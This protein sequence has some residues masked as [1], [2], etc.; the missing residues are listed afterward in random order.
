VKTRRIRFR[1][2][3]SEPLTKH[4]VANDIAMSHLLA[5]LSASFPPGEEAFIRAVR[6]YADQIADPALAQQVKGFIGQEMTHGREHRNLNDTLAAMGYPTKLIEQ[7]VDLVSLVERLIPAIF[8]LAVTAAAEHGTATLA[9]QLLGKPAVQALA[10]DQETLHL[11]NWHAVEEL[12]HKAVAFDVFRAV[13]GGEPVRI[14]AGIFAVAMGV[15]LGLAGTVLS[16]LSDPYTRRHPLRAAH[17]L[18]ALPRRP[19]FRGVPRRIAC[20]LRPGFHPSDMET[21]DLLAAWQE[22]LFGHDGELVDHLK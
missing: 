15:A 19:I 3:D 20:Y 14:A 22:R 11:I 2:A 4:F 5:V 13:G 10:T 6:R 16:M 12:E 18:V 8:P 17:S 9:E 1:F 21:D 7:V